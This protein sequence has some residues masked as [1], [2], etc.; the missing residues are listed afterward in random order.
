MP[1]WSGWEKAEGWKAEGVRCKKNSIPFTF[2]LQIFS[3]RTWKAS[4]APV[5][6]LNPV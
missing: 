2:S 6:V 1:P 3:R 4:L 5:T